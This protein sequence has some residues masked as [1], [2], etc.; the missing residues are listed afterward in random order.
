MCLLK[1]AVRKKTSKSNYDTNVN[2]LA[3]KKVIKFFRQFIINKFVII[4]IKKILLS[5]RRLLVATQPCIYI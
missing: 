1:L 3:H 4:S 2:I 5:V